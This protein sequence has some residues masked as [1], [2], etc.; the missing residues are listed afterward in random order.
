MTMSG[1]GIGL[2]KEKELSEKMSALGIREADIIERFI[3]SR[4]PGGQNVNKTATCVYLKHVPT[5]IE[6]KCQEERVQALNRYIARKILIRK[7]ENLILGK[8][9]Q[10]RKEIEKIRRQKRRRSRRAKLKMLEAKRRQAEKK[11]L[12]AAVRET[13]FP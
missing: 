11:L 12:R 13:E 10:E 5:G 4:G 7:I 3:R 6:V 8:L 2:D 9:S 1:F